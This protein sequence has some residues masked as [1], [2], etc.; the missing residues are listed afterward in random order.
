MYSVFYGCTCIDP[1]YVVTD[2]F[3]G[4]WSIWL[5]QDSY[6]EGM[7]STNV[8]TPAVCQNVDLYPF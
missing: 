8:T 6:I 5:W 7:H 3:T 1:L 2:S 4:V